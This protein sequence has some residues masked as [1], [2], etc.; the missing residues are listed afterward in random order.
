MGAKVSKKAKIRKKKLN[1]SEIRHQD[2]EKIIPYVG[3]VETGNDTEALELLDS[4]PQPPFRTEHLINPRNPI[5]R[6]CPD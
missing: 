5:R 6:L 3:N 1:A 2:V 4:K